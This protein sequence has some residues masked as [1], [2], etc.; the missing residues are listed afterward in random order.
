MIGKYLN[1]RIYNIWLKEF[2]FIHHKKI[3]KEY[4]IF[5][6]KKKNLKCLELIT[7]DNLKLTCSDGVFK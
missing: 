3:L 7:I 4:E 1:S 6:K 2:S 5:I